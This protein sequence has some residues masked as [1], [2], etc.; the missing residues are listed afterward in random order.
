MVYLIVDGVYEAM[1][2]LGQVRDGIL[3]AWGI[4]EDG[5]R[6]LIHL[7]V[8]NRE[9]Y[10]S[11]VGFLRGLKA[12]GLPDPILVTS[13]GAPGMIRA[14]DEV[15]NQSLRQRCL[16][17]K[18]ANVLAKVPETEKAE[19]GAH[20]NAVV[21]PPYPKIARTLADEFAAKYQGALPTAVRCFL[22]DLEACLAH[23]RCLEIHRKAIRTTNVMERAFKELRRRTKVIP[24]FFKERTCL[25][26]AFAELVR[27]GQRGRRVPMSEIE[28]RQLQLL[29]GELHE[30]RRAA[31]PRRTSSDS[32]RVA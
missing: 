5:R 32:T 27:V 13:D 23:L 18:K 21:N 3:V 10:E 16:V 29:G 11:C 17:H 12:R 1:R 31:T 8:G 28:L 19:V 30:E 14:I 20:S 2:R 26:L 22:D 24:R 15:F 6:L 25:K 7:E 4:L 9:S